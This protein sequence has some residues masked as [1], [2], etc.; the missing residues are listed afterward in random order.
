MEGGRATTSFLRTSRSRS[1]SRQAQAKEVAVESA[2]A[3]YSAEPKKH[4]GYGSIKDTLD[5]DPRNGWANFDRD[6]GEPRTAVFAF[7]E[8]LTLAPDEK[9]T[10]ELRHRSTDGYANIG[11][12]RIS[13]TDQAGETVHGVVAAPLD[14]LAAS[15]DLAVDQV[16]GKLKARLFSQYL[17]DDPVHAAAQKALVRASSQW[18]EVKAA[19]K[20]EVMV[21]AERLGAAHHA[22]AGPRCLGQERARGPCR[23]PHL[24]GAFGRTSDRRRA[25]G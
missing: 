18:N 19:E 7:A 8:P 11:R 5:D 10:I 25:S 22:R 4:G 20:V 24:A 23:R 6:P 12:F 13:L 2:V 21:L 9:L 17:L 14:E 1:E 15:G 3:D 16:D